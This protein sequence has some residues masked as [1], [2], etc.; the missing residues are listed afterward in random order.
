MPKA[1]RGDKPSVNNGKLNR[2][3]IL[4]AGTTLAATAIAAN[5]PVQVAQ[6]QTAPPTG[7][8]P[9]IILIASDDFGYGDAGAQID[10]RMVLFSQVKSTF[11]TG[12]AAAHDR[13]AHTGTEFMVSLKIY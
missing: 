11:S 5:S 2:R 8:K 9:N 1:D 3:D 12:F 10:I 7:G 4:L 6:A 13:S